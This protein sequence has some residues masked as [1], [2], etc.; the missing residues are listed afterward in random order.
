M[1]RKLFFLP[2][3]ACF[4]IL[5]SAQQ[6]NRD[7]EPIRLYNSKI[8]KV[9]D[10]DGF[11]IY[12]RESHVVGHKARIK[13]KKYFFSESSTAPIK[14]LTISNLKHAF[15]LNREFHDLIDIHFRNN[16]E[17]TRFDAFYNEYKLKSVYKK[18]FNLQ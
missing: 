13:E 1:I 16:G 17:L 12:S 18:A 4:F 14:P 7:E 8:Y 9:V 15:P 10:R 3:I 2:L 11:V 6:V 5:T